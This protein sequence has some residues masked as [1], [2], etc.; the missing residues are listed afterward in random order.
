E[1]RA[2]L[3][4]ELLLARAERAQPREDR[5]AQRAPRPGEEVRHLRDRQPGRRRELAVRRRSVALGRL[6][7]APPEELEVLR[8]ALGLAAR[9]QVADRRVEERTHPLPLEARVEVAVGRRRRRR[10]EPRVV[11]RERR[12][13]AAPL[14]PRRRLSDVRDE[15][16]EADAQEGPETRALRI[17]A[18]EEV[19]LEGARE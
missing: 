15:A 16:V 3:V 19:L 13:A 18:L 5:F 4:A 8:L 17:E 11:E 1:Q 6:E 9:L 12:D 2:R 7:V 10:L 14:D